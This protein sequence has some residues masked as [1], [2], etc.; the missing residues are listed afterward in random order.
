[1]KKSRKKFQCDY[2]IVNESGNEK[3]VSVSIIS[4]DA[5]SAE[6]FIASNIADDVKIVWHSI[7]EVSKQK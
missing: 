1:M 5:F 7:T 3:F 6:K 4:I 2:T